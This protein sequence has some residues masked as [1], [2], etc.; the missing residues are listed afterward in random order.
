MT[1]A[2][3]NEGVPAA[4]WNQP[5]PPQQAYPQAPQPHQQPQ[6][7]QPYPQQAHP[8]Q[9]WQ[10]PAPPRPAASGSVLRRWPA[11]A[12][13]TALAVGAVAVL[14]V[15]FFAGYFTAHAVDGGQRGG[16]GTTQDFGPRQFGGNGGNGGFGGGTGGS[17]QQGD[18]S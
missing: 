8:Q 1:T 17:L 18:G 3:P 16:F 15:V 11:W 7:A 13:N 4:G 10:P 2:V 14:V 6:P 5:V 9:P 12:Q